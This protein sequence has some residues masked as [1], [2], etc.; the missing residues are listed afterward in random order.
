MGDR[1]EK[2]E[3]ASGKMLGGECWAGGNIQSL[4]RLLTRKRAMGPTDV[5]L[6]REVIWWKKSCW[7]GRKS[8]VIKGEM[9]ILEGN[10][11]LK[12][13]NERA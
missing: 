10:I 11:V 6:K 7:R 8:Q 9:W 5:E 1:F 4:V 12:Q 3:N 2:A 13:E